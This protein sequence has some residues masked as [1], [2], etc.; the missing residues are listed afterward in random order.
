MLKQLIQKLF[1]KNAEKELVKHN[2]KVSF[3]GLEEDHKKKYTLF[4]CVECGKY[5]KVYEED[6][7]NTLDQ[8]YQNEV[9]K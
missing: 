2:W 1:V 9:K 8:A 7:W 3:N 4:S 5:K 6:F